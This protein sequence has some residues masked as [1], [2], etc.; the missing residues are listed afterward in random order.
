M[1][2]QL[3]YFCYYSVGTYLSHQNY[4]PLLRLVLLTQ[5]QVYATL[6]KTGVVY[7][8]DAVVL[9]LSMH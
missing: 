9:S 5:G 8:P 3:K 2:L 1:L 6:E 7:G 4:L